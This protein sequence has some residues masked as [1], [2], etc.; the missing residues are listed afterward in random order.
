LEA[1]VDGPLSDLLNLG[2]DL[3]DVFAQG[4]SMALSAGDSL[5][6]AIGAI[7]ELPSMP[8]P[9]SLPG[10]PGLENFPSPATINIEQDIEELVSSIIAPFESQV[11]DSFE[12]VF[13][14][15]EA[16]SEE[17]ATYGGGVTPF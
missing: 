15:I 4:I 17:I 1:E 3:A 6:G 8:D 13:A 5:S 16:L 14:D 11:E 9:W 2:D 10:L 12:S 7:G